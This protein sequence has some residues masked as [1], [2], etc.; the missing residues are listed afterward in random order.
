[1]FLEGFPYK[2]YEYMAMGKVSLVEN[3]KGVKEILIDGKNSLLYKDSKEFEN[4][5][6]KIMNNPKLKK[7]IE[8]NALIESK[9]HTWYQREKEF[10]K[11]IREISR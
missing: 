3:T 7:R 9:K 1:V 10:N 2:I 5:V 6:L 8:K 4:K 11:I